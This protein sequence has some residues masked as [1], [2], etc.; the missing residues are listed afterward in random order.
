MRSAL[1]VLTLALGS[2]AVLALVAGPT[3]A[4]PP[5]ASYGPVTL[6]V[7]SACN[8]TAKATWSHAKVDSVQFTLHMRGRP[9]RSKLRPRHPR[10][11]RRPPCLRSG[12]AI[13]TPSS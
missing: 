13:H 9:T 10:A 2:S 5:P 1:F 12:P 11:A 7:D 3:A 6:T 4:S 8:F